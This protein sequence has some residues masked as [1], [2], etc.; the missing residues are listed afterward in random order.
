MTI[1]ITPENSAFLFIDVQEKL[2][3][4]LSKDKC[5]KKAEI[6][7]KTAKVLGIKTVLTE[8]YPK[9]LGETIAQVKT[10]IPENALFFEKT[11][12]NAM[13]TDGL[14]QS[15]NGTK[16]IF[17]FGIETHICVYQTVLALLKECFN[18]F[19]IKDA[20]ASREKEEFKTGI[21]LMER[22]GAKIM[23]TEI[24]IFELLKTSK[25]PNFKEIQAF[26][27]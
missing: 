13:E 22:E 8:Q 12:F 4:M 6:L 2:T 26:I 27:K 24:V 10:N 11:S 17:V 9:G 20:C 14:K 25:H 23:T 15:L 21:N 16:N 7:A 1:D 18:V 5:V 19:V 3:G